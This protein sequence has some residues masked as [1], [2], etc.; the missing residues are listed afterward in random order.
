M[1]KASN[2]KHNA[3]E[4]E[5]I[6]RWYFNEWDN[7]DPNATLEN[8]IEKISLNSNRNFFVAHINDQLVGAGELKF[9]EYKEY[10]DYKHWVD[11]IYVPDKHRGKGISTALVEFAKSKAIEQQIPALYL[12]CEKHLVDLY[13]THG[14]NV[15]EKEQAKFIMENKLEILKR[16]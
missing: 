11:G 14:F 2:L 13:K 8:V 4:I 15:V 1:M 9:R 5:T 6:A 10:P 3:S 7:K 12:R 16:V